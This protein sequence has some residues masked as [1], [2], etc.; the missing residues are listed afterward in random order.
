MC[1]QIKSAR[2]AS[3]RSAIERGGMLDWPHT[4][5]HLVEAIQQ[6]DHAA[7]AAEEENYDAALHHI[8]NAHEILFGD[9]PCAA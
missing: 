6:T 7:A 2:T 4:R 9:E 3:A 1:K 5:A 8:R